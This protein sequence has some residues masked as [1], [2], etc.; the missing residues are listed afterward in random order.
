MTRE[1]FEVEFR[2]EFDE[3][4]APLF[5]YLDRLS[6]DPELASDIAQEA[7]V[8]LFRR[9]SM[10]DDVRGWLGVVASNLFR[11]DRRRSQ[12]RVQ[13]LA[14]QPVEVTVGAGATDGSAVDALVSEERRR[15][16]REALDTLGERDRQMLLLRHEG[17]SYREVARAV[18]VSESSVGTLLIRA[19]AAFRAAFL[20][21]NRAFE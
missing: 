11:D 16:V 5:R 1:R 18:G 10:P 4:F 3:R 14:R 19:T 13:L 15:T 8:R 7:F 21:R 20:E 2:R 9:G 12:R 17:Y 6:G